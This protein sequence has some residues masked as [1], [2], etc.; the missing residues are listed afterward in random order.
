M[1]T[2]T[3]DKIWLLRLPV[4]LSDAAWEQ[5]VYIKDC[6]ETEITERLG[7]IFQCIYREL[8]VRPSTDQSDRIY[9]GQYGFP[10]CGNRQFRV[11]LD[12][13]LTIERCDDGEPC[14]L[15][16]TLKDEALP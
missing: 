10:P 1:T 8:R 15:R 12:L 16:V 14:A 7:E 6:T 2:F 3:P 11:W 5:T 13:C 4:I 9:F